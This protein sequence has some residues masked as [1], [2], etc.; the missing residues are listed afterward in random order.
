MLP[1]RG[2]IH[3]HLANFGR[4]DFCGEMS[5]LDQGARS[6]DAIAKTDVDLYA[7]SRAEFNEHVLE[8]AVLGVR[9]FARLA[10]AVSRRL[11]QTDGELRAV[12][13]R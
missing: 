13:E 7:L 6:A 11:R 9:V 4:G 8:D 12:E 5:F 3:H 10:R 1:L 2:G